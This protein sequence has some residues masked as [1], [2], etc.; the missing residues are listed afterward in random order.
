MFSLWSS[1][2]QATEVDVF[3]SEP[4][5]FDELWRNATKVAM[6]G[7]DVAVA[8]I[9]DLIL[10]KGRVGRPKDLQ[11]IEEL[12]KLSALREGKP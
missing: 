3:V 1:R 2:F 4:L 12:R 10:M 6:D 11:D 7:A 8:S 5:P 9:E